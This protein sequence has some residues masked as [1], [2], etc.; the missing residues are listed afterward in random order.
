MNSGQVPANVN[1]LKIAEAAQAKPGPPRVPRQSH[2]TATVEVITPADAAEV[3]KLI[4]SY[5][6]A[7]EMTRDLGAACRDAS[8]RA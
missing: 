1:V 2:S 4:D 6:K 3:G 8:P 7:Y 5:V